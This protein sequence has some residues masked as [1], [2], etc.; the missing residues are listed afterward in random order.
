MFKKVLTVIALMSVGL[1]AYC[2]DKYNEPFTGLN[3][4]ARKQNIVLINRLQAVSEYN[5]L[6]FTKLWPDGYF[7]NDGR[8]TYFYYGENEG[9]SL[10]LI[11]FDILLNQGNCDYTYLCIPKVVPNKLSYRYEERLINDY[12][13]DFVENPKGH[14]VYEVLPDEDSLFRVTQILSNLA[15][16]EPKSEPMCKKGENGIA[17]TC[18]TNDSNGQMLYKEEFYLKNPKKPVNNDNLFKYVKYDAFGKKI[19]EYIYSQNKMTKYD[20]KGE[21]SEQFQLTEDKFLYSNSKL[22]ALYIDMRVKRNELGYPL[23]ETYYERGAIP[24]RKYVGVYKDNVLDRIV[25]YDMFKKDAYEVIPAPVQN[26]APA[27]FKIRY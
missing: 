20:E 21:I 8:L 26:V 17:K 15:D 2:A 25:V 9:D 6:Q 18:I 14:V 5:N 1:S 16:S 7:K 13:P 22:P 23:E 4:I 11:K 19:M 24:V 27:K 10:D 12:V 3:N